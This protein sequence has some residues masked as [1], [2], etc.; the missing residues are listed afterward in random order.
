MKAH[1]ERENV[2]SYEE[3]GTWVYLVVAIVGSTV[4]LSLVLPRVS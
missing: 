2:M 1:S 4:Y 3:K